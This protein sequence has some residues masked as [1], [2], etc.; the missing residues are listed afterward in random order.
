M[1]RKVFADGETIRARITYKDPDTLAVVDPAAVSVS[2]RTPSGVLTTYIYGTDNEVSKVSTGIY[3]VSI[4]LSEVG[5]WK[6]K[7]V[8]T[9]TEK[10]AVDYD[11]CDAEKEAGF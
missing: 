3:Q 1:A 2:V 10:S 7:W 11:E 4:A 5:T 9:G 6:W 8:G